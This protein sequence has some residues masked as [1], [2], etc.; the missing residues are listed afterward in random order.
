MNEDNVKCEIIKDVLPLYID[1]VVSLETKNMVERH[2]LNCEKCK[3]E[4]REMSKEVALPLN[5]DN[6]MFKQLK[7]SFRKRKIKIAIA[8][9]LITAMVIMSIYWFVFNFQRVIP[10][11]NSLFSIETLDGNQLYLQYNGNNYYGSYEAYSIPINIDGEV[12]NVSLIYFTQTLAESPSS[13][14]FNNSNETET[15]YKFKES[16]QIDAI[17]YVDFDTNVSNLE[18]DGEE[19]VGR[20]DLLWKK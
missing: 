16:E 19:I 10:Y 7:V 6:S 11:S 3:E 12:R 14:F 18:D 15:L 17:Y 1:G 13:N 4:Y 5:T 9:S 20:A 2:L 8:T